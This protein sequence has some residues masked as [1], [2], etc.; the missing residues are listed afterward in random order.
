MF[1]KDSFI[2]DSFIKN[3]FIKDDFIKNGFV[4]KLVLIVFCLFSFLVSF[5]NVSE[6][7]NNELKVMMN[8]NQGPVLTMPSMIESVTDTVEMD[9]IVLGYNLP[10][11]IK[12]NEHGKEVF[13]RNNGER[14]YDYVV[15][16]LSLRWNPN[17]GE[18]YKQTLNTTAVLTNGERV[19]LP[20]E[21]TDMVNITNNENNGFWREIYQIAENLYQSNNRKR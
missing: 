20:N 16:R 13:S 5:T 2:K 21:N 14:D 12:L 9:Y 15:S 19:E 11:V 6:S 10:M 4:R 17:T 1:I 18:I 7:A 3:C 8:T